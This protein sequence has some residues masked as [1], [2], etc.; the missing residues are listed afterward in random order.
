MD[1]RLHFDPPAWLLPVW[2]AL[3]PDG[4]DGLGLVLLF[5]A[6]QLA[7]IGLLLGYALLLRLRRR[8]AARRRAKL[9]TVWHY[10]VPAYLSGEID[11]MHLAASLAR[12]DYPLF[13]QF[14]RPYLVDLAGSDARRLSALLSDLG[15]KDYLR[16]FIH[17]R[18]PWRRAYALHFFA[19]IEDPEALPII[20]NALDDRSEFVVYQAAE[21]L[22]RLH[23]FQSIA[24]VLARVS[25]LSN[26]NRERL[27]VYMMEFGVQI[28]P[29]LQQMVRE[30]GAP[31]WLQV[32]VLQVLA[33]HR[34]TPATW[35]ILYRYLHTTER[36]VRIA[37][38]KALAACGE[39]TLVG[40][41]EEMLGD[42]DP[43][44]QAEAA[45]A[46]GQMGESHHAAM[47]ARLLLS[48]DFWVVKHAIGALMRLDMLPWVILQGRYGR[49]QFSATARALIREELAERVLRRK[50]GRA[51]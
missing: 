5:L 21:A 46:I 28:L 49:A 30:A 26:A 36:E 7:L 19:L 10:L 50:Q 6:S 47:L 31:P 24:A 8:L 25:A 29:V 27:A 51:A 48:R 32:V 14:L 16:R 37:C 41:F 43:V 20:R 22:M 38:V 45:K 12:R 3:F 39:P 42:R 1:W 15:F 2:H 17:H 18:S 40:F 44:V 35:D 34:F 9:Y 33:Y 11:Q 23:D 4:V 13:A